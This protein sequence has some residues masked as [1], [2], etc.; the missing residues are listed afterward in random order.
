MRFLLLL[1][2]VS[3]LSCGRSEKKTDVSSETAVESVEA[4]SDL[5]VESMVLSVDGMT[6][7]GCEKTVENAVAAI[8]G[9]KSAKASHTE[10]TT[11]IEFYEGELEKEKVT[12][13]IKAAGYEVIE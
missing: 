13:A 11:L 3:A 4:K 6:C 7:T 8:P 10:K 9:V 5:K 1:I 2:L 12:A